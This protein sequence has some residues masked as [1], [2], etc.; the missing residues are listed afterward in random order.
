MT[1]KNELKYFYNR[2][3]VANKGAVVES[4]GEG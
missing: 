1:E 4:D 2:K 3:N